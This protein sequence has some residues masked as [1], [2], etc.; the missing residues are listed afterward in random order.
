MRNEKGVFNT[1]SDSGP[2]GEERR[3]LK[4]ALSARDA[5]LRKCISVCVCVMMSELAN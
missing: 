4:R 2:S 5:E 3:G 1:W